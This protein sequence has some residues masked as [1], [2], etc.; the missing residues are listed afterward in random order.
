MTKQHI[1]VW[2]YATDEGDLALTADPAKA[3]EWREMFRDRGE[4]LP[5]Q[6]A[7]YPSAKQWAAGKKEIAAMSAAR[8]GQ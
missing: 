4:A 5:V 6:F 8:R 3:K 2:G 7:L 1:I